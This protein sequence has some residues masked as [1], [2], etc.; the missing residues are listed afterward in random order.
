MS[1]LP[2]TSDPNEGAP[3]ID[4]IVGEMNTNS[5]G[6]DAVKMRELNSYSS[7]ACIAEWQKYPL[8]KQLLLGNMPR[9]CVD[10]EMSARQ[11]ALA[12]WVLDV[13]QD[14]PWDHKPKIRKQFHPRVPNG[15][16]VWH[17]LDQFDYFYDIWSNIHYGYV[18]IACGFSKSGLLDGAGLEQIGSDVLRGRMPSSRPGVQGARSYDDPS[19]QESILIGINLY[20]SSPGGVSAKQVRDAVTTAAALT[21]RPTPVAKKAVPAGGPR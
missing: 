5:K 15:E 20:Y 6:N 21:K 14:G 16:Q 3:V 19:D 17:R 11:A 18:G 2:P 9:T 4:Y 8:W 1:T 12:M 13:R 7:Q 10:T